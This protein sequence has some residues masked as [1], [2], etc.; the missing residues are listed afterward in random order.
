MRYGRYNRTAGSAGILAC[1]AMLLAAACGSQSDS[2]TEQMSALGK[3]R[4]ASRLPLDAGREY[5]MEARTRAIAETIRDHGPVTSL[6]TVAGVLSRYRTKVDGVVREY[7]LFV[8]VL[9]PKR[10]ASGVVIRRG[11]FQS[12]AGLSHYFPGEFGGDLYMYCVPC[13]IS[14]A[15]AASQAAVPVIAALPA[16]ML[17]KWPPARIAVLR[18]DGTESDT[19]PV[20]VTK[21]ALREAGEEMTYEDAWL[22]PEAKSKAEFDGSKEIDE[23][24]PAFPEKSR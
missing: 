7:S 10:E 6:T 20:Y 5:Y 22:W 12:S 17:G 18:K 9:D 2:R 21:W 8:F 11:S 23:G 19:A 16:D 3:L 15:G 13:E 24:S 14:K 1:V 4:D